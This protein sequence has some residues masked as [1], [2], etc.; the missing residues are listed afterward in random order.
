MYPELIVGGYGAGLDITNMEI[1][2]Y[3]PS[4]NCFMIDAATNV[5]IPTTCYHS[6]PYPIVGFIILALSFFLLWYFRKEIFGF[7]RDHQVP[8]FPIIIMYV[9]F[10]T[11]FIWFSG[12][13]ISSLFSLFYSIPSM[14]TLSDPEIRHSLSLFN[15]SISMM[16]D[17]GI[18]DRV[19][20]TI[21]KT[22]DCYFWISIIMVIIITI[23]YM[24][25]RFYGNEK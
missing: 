5:R 8:F 9:T 4:N 17:N 15:T 10:N 3:T 19:L 2:I 24:I 12:I 7:M 11:I 20:F 1:D 18:S 13:F 23:W 21:I 16:R 14:L 22:V 6:S 25:Y